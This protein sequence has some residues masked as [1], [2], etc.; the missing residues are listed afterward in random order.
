[1]KPLRSTR[2]ARL[3]TGAFGLVLSAFLLA[4]APASMT[5]ELEAVPGSAD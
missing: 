2:N 3:V 5:D 1:M 4:G